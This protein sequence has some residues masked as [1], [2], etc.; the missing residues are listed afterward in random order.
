MILIRVWGE[1]ILLFLN[2]AH[3]GDKVGNHLGIYSSTLLDNWSSGESVGKDKE[4]EM[5]TGIE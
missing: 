1:N 5:A 2:K 4:H 3:R